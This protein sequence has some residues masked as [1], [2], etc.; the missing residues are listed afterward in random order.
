MNNNETKQEVELEIQEEEKEV[1]NNGSVWGKMSDFG[2]KAAAGAQKGAKIL[3]DKT[4]SAIYASQIK[5][6]NP[7]FPDEY[8][9]ENF[10]LP[11]MIMIVD[12]A[13]RKNVAVCQ[14]A[15]GWLG[16]DT[17]MEVLYLY[18]EFVPECGI[19]FIPTASCDSAYYVDNFDRNRFIRIDCIFSKAHEEKIAELEQIAH[20]LG[21]KSCSIEMIEASTALTSSGRKQGVQITGKVQDDNISIAEQH[22]QSMHTA[23]TNQRS[24]RIVT[25]FKGS[26]AP[27]RPT[28]KWFANDDNIISLIEMRCNDVN[29]VQS[30]TLELAGSSSATM[31]QSQATA[32]DSTINKMKNKA[33]SSI[34]NQAKQENSSKLIYIVEF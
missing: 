32:V 27:T 14:G 15:I 2:K 18:D 22:S 20:A 1:A 4:K 19:K 25:Q 31:S 21:A 9:S 33:T 10:H 8:F 16:N 5:K 7:L 17:G 26:D 3:G 28:L 11:N 6:Y 30:K 23:S 34:E 24:G 13:V 29:S 12:D